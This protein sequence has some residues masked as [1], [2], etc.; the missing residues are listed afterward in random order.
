M[1]LLP[2]HARPTAALLAVALFS[3]SEGRT[4][5]GIPDLY[6]WGAVL[7]FDHYFLVESGWVA[8]NNC[9][10][11]TFDGWFEFTPATAWSMHWS[12]HVDGRD[13]PITG[14]VAAVT[15]GSTVEILGTLT[16]TA[17]DAQY[18]MEFTRTVQAGQRLRAVL[19]LYPSCCVMDEDFRPHDLAFDV[20][21]SSPPCNH[22]TALIQQVDAMTGCPDSSSDDCG[23]V[24]MRP[25][26]FKLSCTYGTTWADLTSVFSTYLAEGSITFPAEADS[27]AFCGAEDE[28]LGLKP[29]YIQLH[30]P[31]RI[32]AMIYELGELVDV[33]LLHYGYP[34][35]VPDHALD[36]R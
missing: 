36:D 28:S 26:E 21:C 30:K 22:M 3:C 24:H 6:D 17:P 12:L 35:W 31:E 9:R 13:V 4:T 7:E 15:A 18:Q 29:Q 33:G 11:P 19:E 1:P 25:V 10:G 5:H 23:N 14:S 32:S 2:R 16:T 20:A 34:V 8:T 27:D